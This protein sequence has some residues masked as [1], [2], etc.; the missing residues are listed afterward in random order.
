MSCHTCRSDDRREYS[1]EMLVHGGGIKNIDNSGVML[2]PK[3]LVCVHCGFSQFT[4]LKA[5]LP[6]LA[7]IQPS[8]RLAAT[9]GH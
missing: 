3:L 8:E 9:T 5:E 4:V 6:S 2:F 7:S 1:A